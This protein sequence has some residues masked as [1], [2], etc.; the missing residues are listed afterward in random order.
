MIAGIIQSRTGSNRC[1][2]KVLKKIKN[3]T[4]VEL[5]VERVRKSLLIDKIII[6]TTINKQDDI[7]E[8][9]SKKIDIDC[10]RG[11]E[12]DLID[13]YYKCSKKYNVDIVV[14]LCND[15]L[16]VDYE[17]I[18]RAIKIFNNNQDKMAIVTNHFKPT[19]PE[20]LDIDVFSFKGL[21]KSWKESTLKSEREHV[22]PYFF[23]NKNKFKIIN[24]EQK[25]NYSYLRWT[26]DYEDDFKMVKEVY[27]HLYD[28]KQYFVQK[29]ILKL[30][31][32]YPEIIKIN[33]DIGHYEGIKK[34]FKE[35]GI[36]NDRYRFLQKNL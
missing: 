24:F 33:S 7:I 2:F 6:A 4:L 8:K 14:R 31:E 22:F 36:K 28:E 34:S 26:I 21:E 18:D 15:D 5:Y 30:L 16:F 25:N 20:G 9:I 10:F 35:D 32:E 19:Y 23:K 12:D 17:V 27:K 29:D 1:S 3:K 11:S 13:R